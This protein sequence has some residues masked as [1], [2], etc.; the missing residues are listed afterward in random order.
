MG[1]VLRFHAISRDST[2]DII[3]SLLGNTRWKVLKFAAE[4]GEVVRHRLVGRSII[5]SGEGEAV[6]HTS[7]SYSRLNT[8]RMTD[9]DLRDC[10][11][12]GQELG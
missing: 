12:A 4:V 8:I 7:G 6:A 9:V 11:I 2:T 5:G 3:G 10:H 1:N